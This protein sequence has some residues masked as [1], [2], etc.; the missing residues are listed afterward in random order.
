MNLLSWPIAGIANVLI[1]SRSV[2]MYN[3][4]FPQYTYSALNQQFD[5][6]IMIH[7]SKLNLRLAQFEVA[8]SICNDS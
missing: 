8:N 4:N 7:D 5:D 3:Y 6:M 1:K 2:D